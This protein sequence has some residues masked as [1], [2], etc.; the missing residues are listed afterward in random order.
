MS[1]DEMDRYWENRVLCSDES[2]IGVIGPN[3]R[4][5][6]CGRPFEGKLP[7]DFNSDDSGAYSEDKFATNPVPTDDEVPPDSQQAVEAEATDDEWSQR[8]LCSDESCIGVIGPDNRCKEC[9]RPY[10]DK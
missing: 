4:C 2:C 1:K 6:E 7:A 3:R 10:S 9:G 5:K 8:T